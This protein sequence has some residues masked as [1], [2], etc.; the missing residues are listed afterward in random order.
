MM[1][2]DTLILSRSTF[3]LVPALLNRHGT[4]WYAPFGTPKVDGWEVVP[5]N[6]TAMADR[7][8]AKLRKK[9]ACVAK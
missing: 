2:A 3:S 9:D 4:V 8:S 1:M 6:I 7:D 5:D